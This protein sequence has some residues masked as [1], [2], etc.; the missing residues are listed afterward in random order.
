VSWTERGILGRSIPLRIINFYS[1]SWK[2]WFLDKSTQEKIAREL[3]ESQTEIERK[4]VEIRQEEEKLLQEGAEYRQKT[5]ARHVKQ[6]IG[7]PYSREY[8]KIIRIA[9]EYG[10]KLYEYFLREYP[11]DWEGRAE[12]VR[13]RDLHAC[14]ECGMRQENET[15]SVHHMIPINA[16][17]PSWTSVEM[18]KDEK[19]TYYDE[20]RTSCGDHYLD[21]LIALCYGCHMRQHPSVMQRWQTRRSDR[22]P[23]S[24]KTNNHQASTEQRKGQVH[25]EDGRHVI[26]TC[27]KCDQRM[28]VLSGRGILTIKCP[29]CSR[30]SRIDSG[31]ESSESEAEQPPP[32]EKRDLALGEKKVFDGWPPRKLSRQG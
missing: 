27:G 24:F 12:A 20:G 14:Q 22:Q 4:R 17:P 2:K 32:S 10:I 26:I 6:N 28:R 19:A 1:H 25:D 29:A 18:I 5:A 13:A 21:N 3:V 11:P 30:E 16:S 8:V 7:N 9:E 15:L 23:T 31:A